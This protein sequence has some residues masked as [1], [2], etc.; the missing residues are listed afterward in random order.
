MN[1]ETKGEDARDGG[2]KGGKEKTIK[3]RVIKP[4][5]W[6]AFSLL[7]KT[8]EGVTAMNAGDSHDAAGVYNVDE[9]LASL[10]L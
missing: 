10:I 5:V 1:R 4:R 6:T 9:F 3:R 7:A 2:K 8:K